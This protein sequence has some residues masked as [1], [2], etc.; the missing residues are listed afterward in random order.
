MK[1]KIALI[2]ERANITL[3]GAEHSVFE[4]TGALS[5]AGL[6]VHVLAAT[7][8]T[9][10]KNTHI[11]C[12]SSVKRTSYHKFA[13]VL[14]EHLSV[15]HYDV[16][17]SVLP[18]DF[19]DIY[20]PRGGTYAEAILRNAASYENKF[21]QSYKRLTS[22]MNLRRSALLH[23]E[24][25]LCQKADGPLIAALSQYVADQIRQHYRTDTHRIALIHNGV[26]TNKRTDTKSDERLRTQILGQLGLKEADNPI[27]LL[28]VAN[29]FRL[30]GLKSLI[31]ALHLVTTNNQAAK[32]VSL[33]VAGKGKTRKYRH[34]AKALNIHH[35]IV[36]LGHIKHIYNLLSIADV[37]VLPTFYDPCSRF[38]LE[39][40]AAGKPVITTT[41]NG[42][43]DLFVNDKHGKVIDTPSNTSALA[44]AIGYFSDIDN[45]RRAS[46][47]IIADKLKEKVSINQVTEK[48]ISL[49]DSILQRKGL[50]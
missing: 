43:T 38:I 45:I 40:L 23:A 44:E 24:R 4:L 39:A 34:F 37:A 19:V 14:K 3:G 48:L 27:L 8:S 29:N 9:N 22:M 26:K 16:I 46:D 49:Y 36:F 21:L 17:H 12:N 1:K 32:N 7:G 10:G 2:I 47:A 11:L 13:K 42:A 50:K 15:N 41:F 33:I 30:K 20:Q 5:S 6:E 25:Q 18:F 28:F 31:K 35:K